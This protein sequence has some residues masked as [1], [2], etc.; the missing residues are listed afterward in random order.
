MQRH[1][2][3]GHSHQHAFTHFNALAPEGLAVCTRRNMLK[4]SLAGIAGLSVPALLQHQAEAAQAGLS[5]PR[6]KSVILLWMTGGASHIDTWDPKPD[7]PIEN[8]GP[9]ATIPTKIPGV[10]IC[11]HLPKQ[12]A[13]LN[14]FTII[15]SVDAQHSNHEPNMAMQTGHGAPD[16]EPRTNRDAPKIPAIASICAKFRGTNV[17]GMP[18]YVAFRKGP[19]HIAYGGYLGRQYDPFIGNDACR[20]PIYTDVGVDTG[21]VSAGGV[22]TLPAGLT[23]DRILR[24]QSLRKQVDTV[25]ADLDRSGVL[26]ALGTYEQQA[27]EMVV[28]GRAREAFDLTREPESVRQRYGTHLWHQQTLLARRLVEAGVAFVTLDLSYHG[29]SGTWDNHGDDIP[30]YGGITSG[31]KPILPLFDHL[32][33]T[34]VSDLEE[35]GLLDDTLV[36]CMGDFGR[37]PIMS[38]FDGRGHWTNVASMAIAGGGFRHGQVIGSTE[39]DGGNIR[40]R[41]VTPGDIAATI[42]HHMGVPLGETYLDHQGRPIN[43]VMD[44]APIREII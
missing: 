16:A 33:T 25:A 18:P 10:R 34:L 41:P 37:G 40:E 23:T 3:S 35:R 39:A 21:K 36:L 7:R 38:K 9:F 20:L 32:V 6:R 27:V 19:S 12:A 4:A 17:P 26:D 11:E 44:G 2:R 30:P 29:A 24:R 42:Y 5:T 31:L 15:R 1:N 8:R 28:G 22:F 43:I 13:M 14:K